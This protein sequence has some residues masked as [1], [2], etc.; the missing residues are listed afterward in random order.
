M[1]RTRVSAPGVALV[2]PRDVPSRRI[3][4]SPLVDRR[5]RIPN[6][7]R[8]RGQQPGGGRSLEP[9]QRGKGRQRSRTSGRALPAGRRVRPRLRACQAPA[10]GCRAVA[11][12]PQE[13]HHPGPRG[14][15][16]GRVVREHGGPRLRPVSGVGQGEADSRPE[17]GSSSRGDQGRDQGA[18]RLLHPGDPGPG[19]ARQRRRSQLQES[20]RSP[21]ADSTRAGHDPPHCFAPGGHGGALGRG[22]RFPRSRPRAGPPGRNLREDASHAATG[23]AAG[24][25]ALEEGRLGRRPVARRP[26]R[27]PGRG[28]VPERSGAARGGHPAE[29]GERPRPGRRRRAQESVRGRALALLCVLLRLAPARGP[30]RRPRWGAASSTASWPRAGYP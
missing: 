27:P 23:A 8:T 20:R 4:T 30:H 29:P 25:R 16:C 28:G 19:L 18:G 14:P 12:Q 10:R 21:S 11:G 1:T 7:R 22:R 6:R 3:R 26:A 24:P 17:E 9:G 2:R 15:G 13:G 5:V